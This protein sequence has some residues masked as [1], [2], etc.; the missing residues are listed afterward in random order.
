VDGKINDMAGYEKQLTSLSASLGALAVTSKTGMGNAGLSISR[1]LGGA[2]YSE[3][4]QLQFFQNNPAFLGQLQKQTGGVELAELG[5]K[6]RSDAILK[7]AQ[8]LAGS[9]DYL[10]QSGKLLD[11]KMSTLMSDLFDPSSGIFGF[12]RDL[13]TEVEGNQSV[14]SSI[15]DSFDLLFGSSGFFS[16]F[17]RMFKSLNFDPM[18]TLFNGITSLNKTAEKMMPFLEQSAAFIDSGGGLGDLFRLIPIWLSDRMKALTDGVLGKLGTINTASFEPFYAGFRNFLGGAVNGAAAFINSVV[19]NAD[20]FWDTI[21]FGAIGLAIGVTLGDLVVAFVD[22]IAK[23]DWFKVLDLFGSGLWKMFNYLTGIVLGL[24][25]RVLQALGDASG[26]AYKRLWDATGNFFN[27][28][29][30]AVTDFFGGMLKRVQG[31]GL[32]AMQGAMNF[33]TNPLGTP[34]ASAKFGGH[35]PTVA[36]SGG[37]FDAI[38]SELRNMPSGASLAIANTSEAILTPRQL[39]NLVSG[40]AAAGVVSNSRSSS[41]SITNHFQIVSNDPDAVAQ[42]VLEIMDTLTDRAADQTLAFI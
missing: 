16:K 25:G 32:G 35:I 34:A 3:L 6:E 17:S 36:A 7:V 30:S 38:F 5:V 41:T 4:Q 1:A 42:K 18:L 27:G 20:K 12:F 24:T 28:I 33:V 11:S 10:K 15:S 2:S 37:L 40:S 22:L 39:N 19:I 26:R 23:V 14:L 21:D 8:Q 9:E 31:A 13:N 29:V